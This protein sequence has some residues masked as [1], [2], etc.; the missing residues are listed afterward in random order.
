MTVRRE[1][2]EFICK[3]PDALGRVT[4]L[5]VRDGKVS[6][7]TESGIEMIVPQHAIVDEDKWV[8]TEPTAKE[9]KP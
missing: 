9:L 3:V 5:V 8:T 7:Q 2:T 6:A 1:G 4:R